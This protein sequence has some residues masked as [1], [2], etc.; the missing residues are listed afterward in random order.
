MTSDPSEKL[1]VVRTVVYGDGT[2]MKNQSSF[3]GL[4]V[5][6]CMTLAAVAAIFSIPSAAA[7]LSCYSV[8]ICRP[9]HQ[10]TI[11]MRLVT[12][13]QRTHIGHTWP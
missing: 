12:A 7:A 13:N 4:G 10:N 1:V 2:S 11:G 3:L 5:S 8:K 6:S 9:N